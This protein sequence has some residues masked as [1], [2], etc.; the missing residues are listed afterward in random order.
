ML[1]KKSLTN[2]TQ[3]T[4]KQVIL[5]IKSQKNKRILN[6]PE[7]MNGKKVNEF[8]ISK[9]VFPEEVPQFV[10]DFK[11]N[12]TIMRL[13]NCVLLFIYLITNHHY[14]KEAVAL[15]S[16]QENRLNEKC[17]LQV[18]YFLVSTF[19]KRFIT[20]YM[21]QTFIN[22]FICYPGLDFEFYITSFGISTKYTI[23]AIIMI[24]QFLKISPFSDIL[25][26][27]SRYTDARAERL[28]ENNGIKADFKFFFK[29]NMRLR[30]LK[31]LVFAYGI[32]LIVFSFCIMIFE[33]QI[34]EGE[35]LDLSQSMW[36]IIVTFNTIGYGDQT[37]ATLWGRVFLIVACI[38]GVS[39][40]SIFVVSSQNLTYF[41][42]E[43]QQAFK[44][45]VI[46]QDKE[47]LKEQ[48][49][50]LIKAF[51]F[52][53]FLK[54]KDKKFMYQRNNS[55]I[56]KLFDILKQAKDMKH[57]KEPE[58]ELLLMKAER[59]ILISKEETELMAEKVDSQ[60]FRVCELM[61]NQKQLSKTIDNCRDL[62]YQL[63][64]FGK[65]LM[66]YGGDFPVYSMNQIEKKRV[67]TSDEIRESIIQHLNENIEDVM[68]KDSQY[69]SDF[70]L[71]H[72]LN[73]QDQIEF[74]QSEDC[75]SSSQNSNESYYSE[76]QSQDNSSYRIP[77]SPQFEQDLSSRI[78][79]ESN[80]YT[81]TETFGHQSFVNKERKTEISQI[82]IS[83]LDDKKT[84]WG[85]T[86]P[87][88]VNEKTSYLT[89]KERM[90]NNLPKLNFDDS[91]K[92]K[93]IKKKHQKKESV[94]P[95][96]RR[97]YDKTNLI[98]QKDELIR[99]NSEH[100]LKQ[101]EGIDKHLRIIKRGIQQKQSKHSLAPIGQKLLT[102]RSANEL[103]NKIQKSPTSLR[104]H[105]EQ[106]AITI[107][108]EETKIPIVKK[109]L[110]KVI[111][112]N[113]YGKRWKYL[114]DN[115]QSPDHKIYL[116]G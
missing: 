78:Q 46:D 68:P 25:L 67:K 69:I 79:N 33:Q 57:Q 22:F 116:K 89:N 35:I 66:E 49:G 6:I 16:L 64:N 2:S 102:D 95:D 98:D 38:W 14:H 86:T 56:P 81:I 34:E 50:K 48:A 36:L 105:Q 94:T 63:A 19:D 28:C 39:I 7:I 90:A 32:G 11:Q 92:V 26:L 80:L 59:Q 52:Y 83:D 97:E 40:Y 108:D 72:N 101:N 13:S 112:F 30:P 54:I 70:I 103:I 55:R 31:I 15:V 4:Q 96:E 21:I 8:E 88:K 87:Q 20:N 99:E 45:I 110:K 113:Q 65:F 62:S 29:V 93:K 51:I 41:Q 58:T 3:K 18:K 114:K 27:R 100:N 77:D 9:Q 106:S 24:L 115:L 75:S 1:I 111:D 10:G 43:D 37:P 104:E 42:Q 82:M 76:N 47:K 73:A 44:Q 61:F 53:N 84:S 5:M 109:K 85:V 12:I 71:Q 74:D 60:G 17:K 91:G 23:G 107:N